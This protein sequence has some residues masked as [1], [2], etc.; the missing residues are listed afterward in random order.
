MERPSKCIDL[1]DYIDNNGPINEK[2]AKIFFK[3]IITSV[4]EMKSNGVLHRDIKDENILVDLNT[5]ELKLIDFGA[6][7]HY[8][9]EPLDTFHGTRVYAPPEWIEN[10]SCLGD[11]SSVWS[12]GVLLFNMIYGDIPFEHDVDIVNCNL[13]FNKYS[14][15]NANRS[16]YC[17]NPNTS[18]Q[19]SEVRDLI[20]KCLK[21]N[22]NERIQL[23]HILNH[24]WLNSNH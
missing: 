4:L 10:E 23:E 7:A 12:L 3:Q 16:N 6:D 5:L 19:Q 8:T 24:S 21:K 2:L 20:R 15:L 1:W 14:N 9:Q 17:A 22:V 13:D 18:Q 11:A